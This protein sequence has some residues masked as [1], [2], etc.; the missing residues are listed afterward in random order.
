MSINNDVDVG[1][2]NNNNNN[3]NDNIIS[4]RKFQ[5]S[6]FSP[7]EQNRTRTI[8]HSGVFFS[9]ARCYHT[10]PLDVRT[11][12]T[13]VCLLAAPPLVLTV[14]AITKYLLKYPVTSRTRIGREK[15]YGTSVP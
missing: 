7:S 8:Y 2:I 3:I 9:F 11:R 10:R 15:P 12:T 14:H 1:I 4:T 5:T 6:S 13:R